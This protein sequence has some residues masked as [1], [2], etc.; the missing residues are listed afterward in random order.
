MT[1]PSRG[2]LFDEGPRSD[3]APKAHGESVFDFTIALTDPIVR[4]EVVPVFV[5]FEVAVHDGEHAA[6][7]RGMVRTQYHIPVEATGET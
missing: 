2:K 4:A 3:P 7:P 6:G 1:S 5:E